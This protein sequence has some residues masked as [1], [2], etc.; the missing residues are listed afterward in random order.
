[1]TIWDK[2]ICTP[3]MF[4]SEIKY[5]IYITDFTSLGSRWGEEGPGQGY[6]GVETRVGRGKG[7]RKVDRGAGGTDKIWQHAE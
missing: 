1:M 5:F 3:G 7:R 2:K 4:T 6:P